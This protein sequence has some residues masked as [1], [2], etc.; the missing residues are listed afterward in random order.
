MG[1]GKDAIGTALDLNVLGDRHFASNLSVIEEE[2]TMGPY[3]MTS[4]QLAL[5]VP[6]KTRKISEASANK[7]SAA[8]F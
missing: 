7:A 1:A 6:F 5:I 4:S 3:I 8:A 2:A